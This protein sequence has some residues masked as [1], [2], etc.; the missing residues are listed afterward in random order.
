MIR[1][2]LAPA[3]ILLALPAQAAQ[4][5][6][7]ARC[8]AFLG[9]WV[10]AATLLPVP[11]DPADAALAAAF[12]AQAEG[13]LTL[14]TGRMAQMIADAVAGDDSAAGRMAATAATCEGEAIRR[15]LL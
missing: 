14:E 3:L 7:A 12:A 15:G 11:Q 13:D 6:T 2:L 1:T 4:A 5:D 8:A 10:Q 9:A